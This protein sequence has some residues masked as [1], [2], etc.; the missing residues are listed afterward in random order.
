[1]VCSNILGSVSDWL[2][3]LVGNLETRY[4]RVCA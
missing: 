2:V 1:M 3:K 4:F